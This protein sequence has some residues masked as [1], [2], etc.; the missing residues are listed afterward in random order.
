MTWP[1]WP[2][3]PCCPT[4]VCAA[5]RLRL[6]PGATCSAG[7]T[8][9]PHHRGPLQDRRRG[10][11]RHSR[12]HSR[13]HAGAGCHPAGGRWRRGEGVRAVGVPDRGGSRPS[14]KPRGWPTGSTSAA[15]AGAWAWPAAWPRTARPPTR[16][17]A[18]AAGNRAAAWSAAT[19]AASPPD[20]RCGICEFTRARN[21][22]TAVQRN[23]LRLH[24]VVIGR[25]D[26]QL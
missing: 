20:R 1:W 22:S 6:S 16:S 10:P 8:E 17:N 4:P 9:R 14:P 21:R 15:T 26:R 18:R 13:R 25:A 7:T 11:G 23:C 3:W 24:R 12:H 19:P 5:P 2:W